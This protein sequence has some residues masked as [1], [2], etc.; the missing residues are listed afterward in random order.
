[1]PY[2]KL[3]DRKELAKNGGLNSV[4]N[5]LLHLS[6]EKRKGAVAYIVMYLAVESFTKDYFGLS[7]GT[8][9]VRSAL[10]ELEN[11]LADYE[12]EKKQQNGAI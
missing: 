2:I 1:M 7:T 9:A 6:T 8:D 3:E 4:W 11:K 10:Y 5:Y 12:Q